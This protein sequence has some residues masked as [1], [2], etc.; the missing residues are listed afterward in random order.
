MRRREDAR[1]YDFTMK[2]H[3]LF[4]DSDI[5]NLPGSQKSNP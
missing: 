5:P 2:N 4:A 3:P 1:L